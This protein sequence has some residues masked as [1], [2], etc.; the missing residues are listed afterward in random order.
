MGLHL[1][2]ACALLLAVGLGGGLARGDEGEPAPLPVPSASRSEHFATSE[3]CALCHSNSP[4][5]QGLRDAQGREVA[6]FNLW[7]ASMMANAARDPLWRAVVSVELAATPSRRADIEATCLRCHSP[8]ASGQAELN[9]ADRPA[10]ELLD[11]AGP[12][13]QLALDGVSCTACHQIQPGN[14][15]APESYSGGFEFG[16]ER[17]IFGPHHDP[18][19]MPMQRH[20]GF[21][22]T[23][24]DH[25]RTSA[26]CATCHT[27]YTDAL[28]ADGHETGHRLPEQ[29]PYLEWRNSNFNDEDDGQ[30][31]SCQTCHMP[32]HDEDGERILTRIARAPHGG[33]FR[34][35]E[36]APFGRHV[37]LG[38]NTLV[39]GM[40][41]DHADELHPLA[42]PEAFQASIDR[43]REQLHTRTARVSIDELA[44][45]A[46][47]LSFTLRVQNMTGHKLPTAHPTRRLWV[48]V[49]VLDAAGQV[50]F[51]SGEH[52][53]RGRILGP[54]GA[55][56]PAELPGGPTYPHRETVD[57]SGQV[58]VYEAVMADA[59]GQPTYLLIRGGRFLK[60]SRLLPRGWRA[61]HPDAAD[62]LPQGVGQDPDYAG[63]EPSDAADR[64]RYV[65]DTGDATG[66]FRV[67]ASLLYQTLGARYAA[68][69]LAY[70]TPEVRRFRRYY[71]A[72]DPG[73]ETV[74]EATAQVE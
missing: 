36:R 1:N 43:I 44:R 70:D 28:D 41:R 45:D 17:Q 67:E 55:P 3:V 65:V 49:R 11:Q 2:R 60:D 46:D 39:L 38:A 61:D 13:G 22:P 54:D 29:T 52:D 24:A 66:P 4:N 53:A 19:T 23:Q 51:A 50:V 10:I 59:E 31:A 64:T 32:T 74:V 73:P 57:A 27:L 69:V 47:G 34:I 71:E 16:T 18:I 7:R 37:F 35:S 56:H 42:P 6:P 62:I 26:M 48:R 9:G 25:V 20:T 63:A 5:A 14:L 40:F 68:E 8:L 21:T 58:Q 15:G 72:A 30:G 12:E 33:D